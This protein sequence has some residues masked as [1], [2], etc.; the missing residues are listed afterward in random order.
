M[1]K[2]IE[3]GEEETV[4]DISISTLIQCLN[5]CGGG[6]GLNTNTTSSLPSKYTNTI[7]SSLPTTSMMLY[8]SDSG[9]PL[10][11]WLEEDGVISGKKL[12][13]TSTKRKMSYFTFYSSC[14]ILYLL[15][16]G[17]LF[18]CNYSNNGWW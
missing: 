16:A 6:T 9:D 12:S 4:F 1:A 11:I 2:E 5:L 3:A 7:V 13:Q 14:S 18:R 15:Y 8:Y 17:Y 10:R